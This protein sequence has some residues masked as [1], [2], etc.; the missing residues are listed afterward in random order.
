MLL[1]QA[2]ITLAT[3]AFEMTLEISKVIQT[4]RSTAYTHNNFQ[5]QLKA[6]MFT[7]HVSVPLLLSSFVLVTL[8]KHWTTELNWARKLL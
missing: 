3:W 1:R 6:S 5:R 8:Q 4:T 7:R 2:I